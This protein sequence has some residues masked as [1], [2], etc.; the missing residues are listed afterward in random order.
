MLCCND[1][2]RHD[3]PVYWTGSDVGKPLAGYY[4]TPYGLPTGA[5]RQVGVGYECEGEH[6]N[7]TYKVV[8]NSESDV[9]R[10]ELE[11]LIP[12]WLTNYRSRYYFFEM[13]ES[14]Y[15][16]LVG[17]VPENRGGGYHTLRV[18]VLSEEFR[19]K[20]RDK[21]HVGNRWGRVDFTRAAVLAYQLSHIMGSELFVLDPVWNVHVE[22]FSVGEDYEW[23]DPY[24]L[25]VVF[26]KSEVN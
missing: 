25:R 1:T 5:Y 4:L 15:I 12:D 24:V 23:G 16:K 22:R 18:L 21:W 3:R 9:Y 26:L 20:V 8:G 10:L 13:V 2:P 7:V 14:V 19:Y 17:P 11:L 6:E